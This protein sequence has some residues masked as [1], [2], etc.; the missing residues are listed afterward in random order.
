MFDIT[1]YEK[2]D[3][4]KTAIKLLSDNPNAKL[5][6]GGTDVLI[7]LREGHDEFSELI[8]IHGL[9]ELKIIQ[10]V[11]G[12]I[13]IG[14]GSTFSEIMENDIILKYVP[15]IA[16]AASTVGGPQVR[17]VATIGGNLCN[18]AIS[19]DSVGSLL[20]L[21]A[22][23]E[24][25]GSKG[26]REVLVKDFYLGPGKVVLEHDEILKN[27]LIKKENYQN[28]GCDYYK[29]AMRNAMD[30][31]TIGCAVA[32]KLNNN[33][34]EDLKIAFTVAAPKP[35]RLETAEKFALGKEISNDLIEEISKLTLED[36][37]PRTSW[38]ATKEFRLHII[39][40]L[41]KRVIAQAVENAGG[42]L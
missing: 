29:Y 40:T 12:D 36:V 28:Y 41:A 24:I 2:A 27:I 30:I 11:A 34:I 39:Q 31:A 20:V 21:D 3:S 6:A 26:S 23:L 17:N 8:D 14:S 25:E 15:V 37:N 1:K 13:K 42:K 9:N 5:I 7:R 10:E 32:C 4:V 19:A 38:R 35:I 18:G 16:K 22:V 33:Q